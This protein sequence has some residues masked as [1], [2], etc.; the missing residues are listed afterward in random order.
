MHSSKLFT[1]IGGLEAAEMRWLHKFLKSPFYNSNQRVLR[2]FEYIKKYYPDLA[3]PKLV[4]EITF[5]YLFPKEKFTPQKMRKLMHELATLVEDFM[6]AQHFQKNPFA[7]KKILTKELGQ[8]N[9]YGLFEKN[10]AEITNEL[11]ELPYRDKD[12]FLEQ[13]LNRYQFLSHPMTPKIQDVEERLLPLS[14][15]L[16]HFYFLQKLKINCDLESA[17]NIYQVK[18]RL[19]LIKQIEEELQEEKYKDLTTVNLYSLANQLFKHK[20][21]IAKFEDFFEAYIN[22]KDKLSLIDKEFFLK[23]LINFTLQKINKGQNFEKFVK[24]SFELYKLGLKENIIVT[25]NVITE[26]TFKNIVSTG[27]YLKEFEFVSQ[28]IDSYK[29]Y[30][31]RKRREKVVLLSKANVKFNLG[32]YS[33]TIDLLLSSTFPMILDKIT[34]RIL[35]VKSYYELFLIDDSY[36]NLLSMQ[37]GNFE[38]NIRREEKISQNKKIGFLNFTKFLKKLLEIKVKKEDLLKFRQ[39]LQSTTSITHKAWLLKKTES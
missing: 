38:K 26:Y 6:V 1:L 17:K 27:C 35:L 21:A 22:K 14:E 25:N 28:F 18:A 31:G 24:T 15:N 30:L 32:D 13:Y 29:N 12:Y 20:D 4:K 2:L 9:V 11:E 3:S 36:Q 7:R 33:S 16:D 34:A 8:R 39:H 10:T 37:I 5:Q 19:P 23:Y